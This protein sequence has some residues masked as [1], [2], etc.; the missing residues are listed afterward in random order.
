MRNRLAIAR[1]EADSAAGQIQEMERTRAQDLEILAELRVENR[2]LGDKRARADAGR[3]AA[4][5][6][7][8]RV[9]K[10]SRTRI[11]ALERQ[12][13]KAASKP[14]SRGTGR[15]PRAASPASGE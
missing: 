5:R 4:E 1:S 10:D 11:A 6:Y 3:E 8:E 13:A 9:Q 7:L 14:A 15:A 2:A 12:L